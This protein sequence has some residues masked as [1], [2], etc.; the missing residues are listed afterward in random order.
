MFHCS[1]QGVRIQGDRGWDGW[2]ASPTRCTWVWVSSG[3]WWRTGRPGVLQS[4][5]LQKAGCNWAITTSEQVWGW[6]FHCAVGR[7]KAFLGSSHRQPEK[8]RQLTTAAEG[9]LTLTLALGEDKKEAS[10][11]VLNGASKAPDLLNQKLQSNG[12]DSYTFF[13]RF[14]RRFGC[15]LLLGRATWPQDKG[16][17]EKRKDSRDHR[18]MQRQIMLTALVPCWHW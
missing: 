3:S 1:L 4:M 15:A 12:Q 8:I 9:M 16:T 14:P 7:K 6:L 2:M 17:S 18:L 5:G 13:F 10:E 11:F